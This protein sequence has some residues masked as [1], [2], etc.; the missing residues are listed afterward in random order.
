[1]AAME[2]TCRV[3]KRTPCAI[4]RPTAAV[5]DSRSAKTAEAGG[6][7]GYDV[8]NKIKGRKRRTLVGTE[9]R[10][11]KRTTFVVNA[12]HIA[13]P[14]ASKR[15]AE[16]PYKFSALTQM[17]RCC[18]DESLRSFPSG[19]CWRHRRRQLFWADASGNGPAACLINSSPRCASQNWRAS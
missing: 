16:Y 9:G 7:C 10:A 17:I 6:P 19:W 15:R 8:G 13:C 12:L 3:E 4:G 5:L 11:L 18:R 2:S 14:S 1:M